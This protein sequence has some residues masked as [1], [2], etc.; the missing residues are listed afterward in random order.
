MGLTGT[1]SA[2]SHP[3]AADRM[4]DRLWGQHLCKRLSNSPCVSQEE[5]LR[6]RSIFL[7][8]RAQCRAFV[9]FASQHR[10]PCNVRDLYAPEA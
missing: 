8:M 5:S 4:F 10:P 3:Y 6:V 7:P 1:R 2:A 9:T